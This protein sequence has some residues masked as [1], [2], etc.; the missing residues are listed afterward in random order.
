MTSKA[1]LLAYNGTL[2]AGWATILAKIAQHFSNGGAVT[3]VYPVIARL[4][5]IFQSAAVMEVLHALLGLVR[6]PVGTTLLQ[7]LS[8]LLVLYGT[9]EI[10]PTAA[11]KSAFATQ[12]VVAWCL[13]ETIRYAYYVSTL[14][15]LRSK[16]I[17]WLRYSAFTV[18]YPMGI[19][20]EI[21]CFICALPYIKE[22]KSW[23]VEL[24]NR[25]NFAFSWYYTALLMLG[26]AYPAGSYIMYTYMLQQRKKALGDAAGSS[27]KELGGE[28][29]RD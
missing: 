14:S 27:V 20:G 29:K 23:S 2:L 21:A 17:T 9:L 19:T 3:E 16:M 12:M 10:G 15:G 24:P 26:L 1:Y 5:V 7:L 6:S 25:F 4:L 13:A 28:K 22:N 18:L 8:R 11:R